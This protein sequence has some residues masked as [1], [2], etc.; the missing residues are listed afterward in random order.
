[1]KEIS[2]PIFYYGIPAL[3]GR[4]SNPRESPADRNA[5][6]CFAGKGQKIDLSMVHVRE[7]SFMQGLFLPGGTDLLPA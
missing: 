3:S 4:E 1:M 7:K 2:H 6:F 5:Q